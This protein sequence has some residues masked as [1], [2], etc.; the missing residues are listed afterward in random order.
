MCTRGLGRDDTAVGTR[1]LGRDDTAVCTRG[2]GRDDTAVCTRGLGRDDTAVCTR[3][4]GPEGT[5]L[6]IRGLGLEGT[7]VCTCGLVPRGRLASSFLTSVPCFHTGRSQTS[8]ASPI[9][10]TASSWRGTIS[11]FHRS[12]WV[13]ESEAMATPLPRRLGRW[14]SDGLGSQQRSCPMLWP[15]AT[16]FAPPACPVHQ[17][18]LQTHQNTVGRITFLVKL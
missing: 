2:L 17:A 16:S 12:A 8:S 7:A 10:G 14:L 15:Q 5:A 11:P 13:S 6:C 1:G 3:G 18:V 4:L 9:S